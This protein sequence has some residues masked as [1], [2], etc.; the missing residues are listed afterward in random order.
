MPAT[1]PPKESSKI[2]TVVAEVLMIDGDFYILRGER[3]EIRIEVTPKTTLSE[4]FK[5][6][7]KIKARI[8]PNDTALSIERAKPDEPFGVHTPP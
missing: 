4:S 3:G 8:L 2:R 7:D 5:F 6:G 1:A